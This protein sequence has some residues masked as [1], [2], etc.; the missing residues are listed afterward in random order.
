MKMKRAI[1]MAP[2]MMAMLSPT[3]PGRQR[4]LARSPVA[5]NAARTSASS[6]TSSS[7]PGAW[8]GPPP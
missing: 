1:V 6:S 2:W 5:A 3:L 8:S 7:I 4:F